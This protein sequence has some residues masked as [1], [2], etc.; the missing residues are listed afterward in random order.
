MLYIVLY[1]IQHTTIQGIHKMALTTQGIH[2]TA[3][4][5]SDQGIKPTL[6][7]V[8]KALGGGSFTTISDAMKSW[9]QEQQAEQQL[10]RVDL[11]SSINERLQS[12]GADMWQSALNIANERLTAERE[13]LAVAQAKAQAETDE[14]QEAVKTLEAEQA[15]LLEQLDAHQTQA[16]QATDNATQS[17]TALDTATAQHKTDIDA[18]KQQLSDTQHKLELEQQR[19]NTTEKTANG[20]RLKLDEIGAQLTQSRESIATSDAQRTAQQAEIERL[21]SELAESKA[22]NTQKDA[23]IEQ[24][25]NERNALDTEL[26][27]KAGRLEVTTEQLASLTADNRQL[28]SENKTMSIEISTI[29]A[30][31]DKLTTEAK[32]K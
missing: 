28:L 12:L 10:Q 32:K 9:R 4:A 1:Y 16:E 25:A 19:S 26:A 8:R 20:L 31:R 5:L 7:E 3:D 18:I 11:P 30:E 15:E 24:L 2:A 13:A 23:K 17:R 22:L 6:A 29:T 14:A 27:N 21:K